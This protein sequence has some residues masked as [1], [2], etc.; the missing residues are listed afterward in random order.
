MEGFVAARMRPRLHR[1]L[2]PGLLAAFLGASAAGG[3]DAPRPVR[4]E[5]VVV[6]GRAVLL[7]EA[8]KE[9]KLDVAVDAEPAA[10]QVVIIGDDGAVTPL[11]ADVSSRALF[12]DDRLRGGRVEITGRRFARLPYLQTITFRV[13]RDGRFRTPEYYCNICTIS[14]R[15]PQTC[16]CCQGD[17]E[18]RMKPERP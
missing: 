4:V 2:I 12:Q 14:V 9:R 11:L 5:E 18:L 6:R 1:F 16:P 15:F 8:L 10:S 13:E 17:M 7:S 3:E